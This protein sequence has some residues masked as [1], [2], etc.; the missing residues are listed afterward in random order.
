M[1]FYNI[2]LPYDQYYLFDLD[3]LKDDECLAEFRAIKRDMPLLKEALQ[4]PDE[5]TLEQRSVVGERK[6]YACS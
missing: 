2:R 6:A 1:C 3:D 5:F 4:I